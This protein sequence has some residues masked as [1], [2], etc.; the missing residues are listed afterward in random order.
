MSDEIM[1]E[2]WRIKDTMARAHGYDIEK[3]VAHIRNRTRANE[4]Q[5][6]SGFTSKTVTGAALAG[7]PHSRDEPPTD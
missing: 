6:G 3:L 1:Q 5:A 2:L 4:R 7:T